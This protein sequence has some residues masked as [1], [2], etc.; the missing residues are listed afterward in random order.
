MGEIRIVAT[1]WPVRQRTGG[2]GAV[3]LAGMVA[4]QVA[5]GL[6]PESV[7]LVGLVVLLLA[8]SA[9]ALTAAAASWSTA[10]AA[11]LA[12]AGVGLVAEWVGTRTGFPFGDYAYTDVLWPQI[13]GVPVLVA[14]AW[15]GMGLA[16]YAVA[17]GGGAVRVATGALALTAWDLFLDPQMLRLGA[18]SWAGDGVYRDV[19]SSNFAGWL[20]VSA[21]V[22]AVIHTIVGRSASGA[23]GLVGLYTV[24]AVMETIGF[25]AVFDPPDPWVALTG[26]TAMGVFTVLAWKRW[27]GGGRG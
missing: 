26:G 24:M 17:P 27:S 6:N 14:L 25:A 18:W 8:G 20:L 11:F 7:G 10:L 2:L 9:V 16:A 22:M 15:A 3:L 4:A 19:P 21:V 5:S 13:G 23:T 1:A 12:V